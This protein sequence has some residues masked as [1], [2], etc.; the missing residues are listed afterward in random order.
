[1]IDCCA[2][3]SVSVLFDILFSVVAS[4]V[5][6][7]GDPLGGCRVTP[8]GYSVLLKKVLSNAWSQLP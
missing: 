1:M 2:F 6:A 4:F 8:Y 5:I 7:V 3:Y